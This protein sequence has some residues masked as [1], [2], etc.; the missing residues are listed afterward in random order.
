MMRRVGISWPDV[1]FGAG[2]LALAGFAGRQV[3]RLPKVWRGE[4]LLTLP[5]PNYHGPEVNHRSFP[6]FQV[7]SPASGE[8]RCWSGSPS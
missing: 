5:W 3:G 8:G 6:A 1:F 4:T 7:S 2:V